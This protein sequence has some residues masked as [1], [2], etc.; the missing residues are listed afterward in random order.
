MEIVPSLEEHPLHRNELYRTP[1]IG[2]VT[3]MGLLANGWKIRLLDNPYGPA[4]A[5]ITHCLY[6]GSRGLRQLTPGVMQSLDQECSDPEPI[7]FDDRMY[8]LDVPFKDKDAVKEAGGQWSPLFKRWCCMPKDKELFQQWLTKPECIVKDLD[9]LIKLNVPRE[10]VKYAKKAGAIWHDS[11]QAKGWFGIRGLRS[12]Y[13]E[14]L[15]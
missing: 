3:A 14:W 4:E 7:K 12:H 5:R 11:Y 1:R 2:F 8:V 9:D 10:D 15:Y 6:D 13:I